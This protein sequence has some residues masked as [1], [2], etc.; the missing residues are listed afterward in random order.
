ML[1]R[2]EFNKAALVAA[3]SGCGTATVAARQTACPDIPWDLFCDIDAFKWDLAR[4]FVKSGVK[5][6]TDSKIMIWSPTDEADTEGRLPNAK[7]LV[8]QLLAD[9]ASWSPW[10]EPNY[11]IDERF[12]PLDMCW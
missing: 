7:G 12:Y 11:L 2:R 10:P 6:A 8:D 3:I 5:F 1:T 9:D 4:P